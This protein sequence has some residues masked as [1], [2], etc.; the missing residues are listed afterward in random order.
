MTTKVAISATF[1][2]T[3]SMHKEHRRRSI[4]KAITYRFISIMVDTVIAYA[5]THSAE[6]TL[7]FVIISNT[8]SIV[9]YFIHERVWNRVPWGRHVA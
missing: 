1:L 2:Y 6:K 7:L 9:V 4:L 8:I 3:S 5:I